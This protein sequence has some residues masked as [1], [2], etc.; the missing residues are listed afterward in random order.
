MATVGDSTRRDM[1]LM[2]KPDQLKIDQD[3]TEHNIGSDI[4]PER[5]LRKPPR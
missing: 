4:H 1:S 5:Q 2:K 3:I